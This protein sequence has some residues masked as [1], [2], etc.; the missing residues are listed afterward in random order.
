M[1]NV[2][3][4]KNDTLQLGQIYDPVSPNKIFLAFVCQRE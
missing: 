3:K 2:I 1:R 4:Y